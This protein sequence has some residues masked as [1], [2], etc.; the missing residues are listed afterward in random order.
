MN[1]AS[2]RKLSYK[3]YLEGTKKVLIASRNEKFPYL[4]MVAG[5]E[6]KINSGVFS[7][8]YFNDTEIFA[9]HLPIVK[10]EEMLEIGPGSGI[11]SIIAAYQGVKK[12]VAID[13][14]PKAVI[15]TQQNIEKHHMQYKVEVRHGD[16]FGP[17]SKEEKFD[18]IFW[19]TPFGIVNDKKLDDL[20][21]SV[22]D[23]EYKSTERFINGA[24]NHLKMGVES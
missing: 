3:D 11:I 17:L 13:I 16:L 14:N 24:K 10:D 2:S 6:F 8:K 9:L 5:K 1:K 18:T 7:P 15:N 23:P 21:K 4:T 19:N 20:E 22:F 12:V